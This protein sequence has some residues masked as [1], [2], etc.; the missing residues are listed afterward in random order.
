M[1]KTE[2][3]KNGGHMP[4]G[5]GNGRQVTPVHE[6]SMSSYQLFAW[7]DAMTVAEMI[8]TTIGA[9]KAK[10]VFDSF[11]TTG[12]IKFENKNSDLIAEFIQ[13]PANQ[14]QSLLKQISAGVSEETT[15]VFLTLVLLGLMRVKELIEIRDRYRSFLAPGE[16]NKATVAALYG[17]E[18][19]VLMQL[20]YTWP[21]EPFTA[22]GIFTDEDEDDL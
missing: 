12:L 21:D 1:I 4:R 10:R 18:R 5:Y 16:G 15:I 8:D 7:R 3:Q 6:K 9:V 19:A 2:F 22:I 14:R 17:F 13:K 11:D 20:N